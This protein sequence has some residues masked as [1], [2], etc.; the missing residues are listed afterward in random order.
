MK[1]KCFKCGESL[2]LEMFYKHPMMAD[3]Y[4]NKC[5][6]CAKK[7]IT[8]NRSINIDYYR[9]YDRKRGARQTPSYQVEY[10]KKY[11]Q[12]YMAASIVNYAIKSK[13]LFKQ[14]CEICGT[15]KSIHAHHD[16]YSM[17][18]NIRWLCAAHHKQWHSKNGEG[19]NTK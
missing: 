18:L 1:K 19:R 6:E 13:K 5:K 14:P 9:E 16:D 12:K 3:G 8:L 7:D 2:S 15:K 4:L 10:R 17:P 11:P